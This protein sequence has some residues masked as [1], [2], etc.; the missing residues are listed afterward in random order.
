[1]NLKTPPQRHGRTDGNAPGS[2]GSRSAY[3]SGGRPETGKALMARR[4][5]CVAVVHPHIAA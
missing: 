3:P 4:D 5:L 1:M 2:R